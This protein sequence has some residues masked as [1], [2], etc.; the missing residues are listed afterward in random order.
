V[1]KSV[2]VELE[3]LAQ[4]LHQPSLARADGRFPVYVIFTTRNGLEDQYG[5]Q[6]KSVID[7]EMRH[8]AAVVARR[9]GWQS[10]V[11]YADDPAF[12]NQY[13]LEPANP[14]DPWK[15]KHA[16]VDLDAALSKRGEMIGALLIVGGDTVVPFHHLPN[17]TEDSDLDV[18]SDSPY[19][20]LDSNY[21][22]PEWP[23]GRLPGE[24]GPDSGTLLEQIRQVEHYHAHR[25][26][27][28]MPFGKEWI[29]WIKARIEDMAPNR[30][31]HSFG[32]TAAVWRRSSLAV[33]RPIGAPHTVL[34]SPPAF[35]GGLKRKVT[36]N[37][38]YYNLHG[39]EDSPVWYGQRDPLEAGAAPDYPVAL[40]PED[41][42]RNGRSPKFVFSEACYGGHVFGKTEK[43][44]LA[45]KFISIGTLGMV[46][47]TC[48]SYGSVSTPL[49][50]ADLLGHLFWQQLKSGKT[51]GE[52]L[53]IAKVQLVREMNRRQGYLD[54]EDQKTL[55]SFLL[56][57]DPLA[58]YD[59]F[60]VRSKGI[61]RSKEHPIVR[62]TSE[63]SQEVLLPGN[64][65]AGVIKEVKQVV[66]EYLP[67]ADVAG[68]RF[69]RLRMDHL[70]KEP[71]AGGA[72]LS[73]RKSGK[74]ASGRLVVTVSKQV[75]VA[76]HLH[77]H[78]MHVTMD[79]AGKMLK[80]A[81]SR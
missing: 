56:Y 9:K 63:E 53:M 64:V 31:P 24:A 51:A 30:S 74:D 71:P 10:I 55:I 12:T 65:P 76:Q 73:G 35:S 39:L 33:F 81:L 16:L 67:G 42:H 69:C 50:G 37:L 22:I 41:L 32:Y 34:A 20:T 43:D 28:K 7:A 59:G 29:I 52:A 57:G 15:L 78:Y 46:A 45:L 13:G 5:P 25:V 38:G 27:G 66:A 44:S 79:D 68:I 3:K 48:V 58:G 26:K 18:P 36:A 14:Q 54:G 2:E 11:Y 70:E 17:P 23:V 6:T 60:R 49:I 75:Q 40:S 21:F 77:C 19:A 72:Y 47:S 62:T 1:Q 8:L 61:A 4:E 80:D